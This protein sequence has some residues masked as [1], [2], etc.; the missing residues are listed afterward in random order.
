VRA[1]AGRWVSAERRDARRDHILDIT[2]E[3]LARHGYE[4]TSMHKVAGGARTSKETLYAW[5]GDKAGLF[6]ALVSREAQAMNDE[7][8]AALAA[9]EPGGDARETL[10]RFGTDVLTLLLG[11]RS[12]TINRAA[13]AAAST[14]PELGRILAA[15]GRETTRPLVQRHLTAEHRAGRLNIPDADEAFEL[16]MGL[17][18]RDL[19]VRLLIGATAAP[20]AKEL[21]PPRRGRRRRLPATPLRVTTRSRTGSPRPSSPRCRR[22]SS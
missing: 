15:K 11:P 2:L 16:L 18:L 7:L 21:T 12:L 19:Q 9:E 20:A 17:L 4:G 3:L 6:E 13:I 22:S 5:F 1:A 8:A 10:V 14:S